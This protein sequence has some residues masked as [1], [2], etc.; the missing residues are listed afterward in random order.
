VVAIIGRRAGRAGAVHWTIA[1]GALNVGGGVWAIA[2]G[3]GDGVVG[4]VLGAANRGPGRGRRPPRHRLLDRAGLTMKRLTLLLVVVL[5]LAA[6]GSACGNDDGTEPESAPEALTR[7][8]FVEQAN[9]LCTD[10]DAHIGEVIGELFAT[11]EPA[12]ADMQAALNEIVATR[13]TLADDLDALAELSEQS[14]EV[15]GMV[16]ALDAATDDAESQ[17]AVAFASDDNPWADAQAMAAGLGLDACAA[18]AG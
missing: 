1:V 5:G 6:V 10:N 12:P 11:G 9:A 15:A 18:D 16:T 17:D 13:R 14:D 2:D 3:R 8:E 7:D 4:V